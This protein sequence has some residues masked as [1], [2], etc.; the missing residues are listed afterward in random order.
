MQSS[1]LR[2]YG[3]V[4]GKKLVI[5]PIATEIFVL[6]C[7]IQLQSSLKEGVAAYCTVQPKLPQG[8][9]EGIAFHIHI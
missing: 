9:K 7:F 3:T 5:S 6:L 2:M 4:R 8:Y 1:Q